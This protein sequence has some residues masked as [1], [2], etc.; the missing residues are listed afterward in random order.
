MVC[1]AVSFMWSLLC[2]SDGLFEFSKGGGTSQW[3]WGKTFWKTG[4]GR[5]CMGE[6]DG[7]VVFWGGGCLRGFKDSVF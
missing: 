1:F 3:D 6:G 4:S 7:V 2:N 5:K